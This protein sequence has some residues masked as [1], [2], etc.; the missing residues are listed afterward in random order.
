MRGGGLIIVGGV[1]VGGV[2]KMGWD[3]LEVAVGGFL[4]MIMMAV[5]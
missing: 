4:R 1:M 3:K 5:R 2:G